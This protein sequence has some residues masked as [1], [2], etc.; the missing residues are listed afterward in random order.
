MPIRIFILLFLLISNVNAQTL[1]NCEWDNR[2]NIPCIT[3]SKTSNTSAYSN[4]GIN[5]I[6]ISKEDIDKSGAKDMASILKLISGLSVFQDGPK[7]QKTSIFMR[8]TNSNHTL[9][10]L[11]GIPINDQSTTQG[12]HDFG[13]DFI[14]SIQQIEVYTGPNGAHFGPSAIGG[15]INFITGNDFNNKIEVSGFNNK[16]KTIKS[17]AIA[18]LFVYVLSPV[19]VRQF[20][21]THIILF[22]GFQEAL[23]YMVRITDKLLE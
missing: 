4:Q 23:G 8:G 12:L 20:L 16:N 1:E 13:V 17:P 2:D 6:I 5:K 15:A 22:T 11:N 9:V 21:L 19:L 14:Q 3:V 18:G 7:G 10:L